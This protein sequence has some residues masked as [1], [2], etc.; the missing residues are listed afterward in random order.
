MSIWL[1][2]FAI[3][4]ESVLLCLKWEQLWSK[5]LSA[6]QADAENVGVAHFIPLLLV[7]VDQVECTVQLLGQGPNMQTRRRLNFGEGD[8]LLA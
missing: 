7:T 4:E 3:S 1:A 6:G 2:L 5:N 8:F